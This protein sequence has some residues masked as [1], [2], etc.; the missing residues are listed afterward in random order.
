[1]WQ[2]KNP[3]LELKGFFITQFYGSVQQI[4]V[5]IKSSSPYSGNKA[6]EILITIYYQGF[7][8]VIFIFV[9]GIQ[10]ISSKRASVVWWRCLEF[11]KTTWK[12]NSVDRLQNVKWR[13]A[14]QPDKKSIFISGSPRNLCPLPKTVENSVDAALVQ[15]FKV[16][17][18]TKCISLQSTLI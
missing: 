8:K 11:L 9:I 16:H 7:V 12:R 13:R 6:I 15:A 3:F 14:Q 2:K 10:G 5:H 18:E 4:L 17:L 1:M